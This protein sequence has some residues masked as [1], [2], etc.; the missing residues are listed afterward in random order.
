MPSSARREIPAAARE[1]RWTAADGTAI[2]RI[3]WPVPD[4]GHCRGSILFMPGRGDAYEK[5]LETL[6]GWHAEGWAVTSADWR[7]QA[8]SGRFGHDGLTGHVDDFSIWINDLAALWDDWCKARPGPHVLVAHSMGGHIALRAVAEG[9][10]TPDALVLS[11]P[12]LGLLP[13]WIPSRVLHPVALVMA[14]L[15]DLRRPAW[16]GSEKP[17]LVPTAR[18]LLLTHDVSRYEDEQWWRKKRPDLAM[19][20]ASWG[21]IERALASIRELERPGILESVQVPVLL[22]GTSADRLVAWQAIRR[23]AR[24][25]P[26][27]ELVT[28]GRECRHEILREA[29]PVRDRALDAIRAFLDRVAPARR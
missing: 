4:A 15:G 1:T 22:L 3:D 13:G 20:A 7:G 2:R 19:G 18:S 11:A 29:D 16:R 12:M 10:V 25:L 5:W 21:W 14:G 9:K 28:F 6:D 17:A 24:R 23:A 26:R 27:G 8:L